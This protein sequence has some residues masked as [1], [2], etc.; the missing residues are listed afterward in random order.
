V[1]FLVTETLDNDGLGETY[2]PETFEITERN[3]KEMD[4]SK[5]Y[6]SQ[7]SFTDALEN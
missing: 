3:I 7:E 4:F 2:G 6:I 5:V 1:K